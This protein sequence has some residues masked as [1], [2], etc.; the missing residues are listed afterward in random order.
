MQLEK[1]GFTL[2]EVLI[3]SCV[4]VVLFYGAWEMFTT[5]RK[6]NDISN[7]QS[8]RQTELRLGF[9]RLREDLQEASYPSRVT[10]ASSER[11]EEDS[12]KL[13]FKDAGPHSLTDSTD[14]ELL[15]FYVCKPSK[16][17]GLGNDSVG[18]VAHCV[19]KAEGRALRYSKSY[20]AV[21]GESAPDSD[22]PPA[23]DKVIVN[24]VDEV[25]VECTAAASAEYDA[26]FCNVSVTCTHPI[27]NLN[28]KVTESTGTKV[29]VAA[30]AF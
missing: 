21:P 30:E 17:V 16:Q 15:S 2:V 10:R 1:R 18:Y 7:W 29:E 27:E 19:L 22:H 28:T 26:W 6:M 11:L 3:A 23:F 20:E 25:K 8:A 4:C 9:Q 14:M 5:L 12:H 24:N 13:E